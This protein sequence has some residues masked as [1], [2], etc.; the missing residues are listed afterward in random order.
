M[1][2]KSKEGGGERSKLE[3]ASAKKNNQ[4][5][6]GDPKEKEPSGGNRLQVK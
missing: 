3:H 4:R 2:S 6:L 5:Y 1:E